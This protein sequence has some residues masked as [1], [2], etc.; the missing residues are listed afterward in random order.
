MLKKLTALKLNRNKGFTLI[1]LI[2]VIAILGILIA[3]LIPSMTGFLDN[4]R[5]VSV[6]AE[7]KTILNGAQTFAGE[8]VLIEGQTVS[9]AQVT[10]QQLVSYNL[11]DANILSDGGTLTEMTI[12]ADG[13]TVTHF[14]WTHNGYQAVYDSANNPQWTCSAVSGGAG[15]AGGNGNQGPGNNNGNGNQ[16]PGGDNANKGRAIITAMVTQTL[17]AKTH[18]NLDNFSPVFSL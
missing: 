10:L 13:L 8:K 17:A 18:N 15:G 11:V 1:E 4:A 16:N 12:G 14:K 6:K 5:K 3:I 7:A 9:G 2:I